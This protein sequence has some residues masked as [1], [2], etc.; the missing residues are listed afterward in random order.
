MVVVQV[1]SYATPEV[2]DK[3]V[4][5]NGVSVFAQ[6]VPA[7]YSV[8]LGVWVRVGSRDEQVRVAGISHFI[9]HMVFKGTENRSAY[10][11]ALALE[12]VGG[13]IEAHTTKEYTCYYTRVLREHFALALDVISDLVLRPVHRPEDIKLEQGVVV[14][15]I[16]NVF[17]TPDDWIFEILSEKIYGKHVMARPILGSRESVTG[18]QQADLRRHMLEHYVGENV[19]ISVAGDVDVKSVYAKIEAA[20]QFPPGKVR[21]AVAAMPETRGGSHFQVDDKLTQ[22][23]LALASRTMSYDADDRFALLL[24]SALM[25]GGMSSRLFQSVRENAGLCYAVHGFTEFARDGGMGGTFLAVSPENTRAALDLVWLEY[26]KLCREGI[27]QRELD[28]TRDQLK[29]SMLLGME[30]AASKMSRMAKN[31]MYYGRQIGVQEVVERLDAITRDDVMRMA[32]AYYGRDR[33]FVV[34]LGPLSGV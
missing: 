13:S 21:H 11:I 30:G 5:A 3:R 34:G 16:N 25:G 14:E 29:G 10:E 15:E 19:V 31:E 22:Q 20:F 7:T 17:D 24:T 28:D 2:I 23:Y 4:L 9:E 18:L 32:N 1:S 26:D 27:S 6:H 33:N 8:V 12:R